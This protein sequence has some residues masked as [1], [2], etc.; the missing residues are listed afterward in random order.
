VADGTG[1][2]RIVNSV[3]SIA[4]R[5]RDV[6]TIKKVKP[7]T[8][9]PSGNVSGTLTLLDTPVTV[10]EVLNST[11]FAWTTV[12]VYGFIPATPKA[13]WVQI[14]GE[15]NGGFSGAI[16]TVQVRRDNF[17]IA[18]VYEA[19]AVYID[20]VSNRMLIPVSQAGTFEIQLVDSV[21]KNYNIYVILEGYLV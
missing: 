5:L 1:S 11:D 2:D 21:I 9:P 8:T 18:P 19:L 3:A 20:R 14:I 4:T 15:R 6:E 10:F 16:G 7:N 13:I 17:S 12:N